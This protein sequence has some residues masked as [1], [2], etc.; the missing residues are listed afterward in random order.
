MGQPLAAPVRETI[1]QGAPDELSVL[2]ADAGADAFELIVGARHVLDCDHVIVHAADALVE[3]DLTAALSRVDS[4]AVDVVVVVGPD[5]PQAP[6]APAANPGS[7]SG[8]EAAR[9]G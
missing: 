2:A 7:A 8:A 5:G 3:H 1:G 9:P 6:V 4:R